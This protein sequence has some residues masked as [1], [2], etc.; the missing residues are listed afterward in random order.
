[1]LAVFGCIEWFF[2]FV[3]LLAIFVLQV[4][5]CVCVCVQSAYP[6]PS[7]ISRPLFSTFAL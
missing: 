2:V 5:V 7:S 3:G 4:C 1:M 6:S